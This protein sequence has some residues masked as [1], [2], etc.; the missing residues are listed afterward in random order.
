VLLLSTLVLALVYGKLALGR[1][2]T[3]GLKN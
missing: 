3:G 2:T 1:Q